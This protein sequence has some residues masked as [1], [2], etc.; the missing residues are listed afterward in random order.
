MIE[1]I[2]LHYALV[3]L[4]KNLETTEE[5]GFIHYQ[6]LSFAGIDRYCTKLN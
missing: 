6:Q 4:N 2:E 1:Q 5:R 3:M